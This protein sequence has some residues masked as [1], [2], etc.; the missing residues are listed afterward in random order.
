M[1]TGTGHQGGGRFTAVGPAEDNARSGEK[2]V[3]PGLAV[4]RGYAA[5]LRVGLGRRQRRRGL[6]D[7]NGFPGQHRLVDETAA[8]DEDAVAR[9]AR[10]RVQWQP[11]HI[12][13][14][15]VH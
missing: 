6:A 15:K 3:T 4:L 10:V 8:T 9:N 12:A 5:Q 11:K 1:R 2:R 14:H 13:R 7:R